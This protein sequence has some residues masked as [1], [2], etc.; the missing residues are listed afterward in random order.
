MSDKLKGSQE[1]RQNAATSFIALSGLSRRWSGTPQGQD[2]FIKTCNSGPRVSHSAHLLHKDSSRFSSKSDD[3]A[4]LERHSD[5]DPG[6][7]SEQTDYSKNE[8]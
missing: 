1:L 3:R 7:T 8:Y 2:N 6:A 5:R 4:F